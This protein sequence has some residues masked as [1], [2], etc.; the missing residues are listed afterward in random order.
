M[1]SPL[2]E[3]DLL[4]S[5]QGSSTNILKLIRTSASSPLKPRLFGNRSSI[6][7]IPDVLT[8]DEL[9]IETS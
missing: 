2:K 7:A 9:T 1:M 5:N 6:L 4:T 8:L 3:S